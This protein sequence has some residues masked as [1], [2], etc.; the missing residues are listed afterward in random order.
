MKI[1]FTQIKELYDFLK[2]TQ[3]ING[4]VIL[5]QGHYT[6]D[7]SSILGLFALNL[8]EPI[9]LEVDNNDYNQFAQYEVQ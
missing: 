1:K 6:V 9:T 4:K 2:I 7:G 5:K 8:L 3:G